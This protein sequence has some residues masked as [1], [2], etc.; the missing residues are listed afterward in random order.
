MDA[1]LLLLRKALND[2]EAEFRPGQAEAV[3]AALEPPFRALVVQA[4]GWGKSMVYFLATRLLRDRGRGPTLVVSPLLSL[5]RN[6]VLAA[7]N[8]GLEAE[9]YTS[10]NKDAWQDVEKAITNNE[11]DLLLVSPERLA[12]EQFQQFIASSSL[13]KVG[14]IVIDEAHCISDWG[15]DFR[16]DYQRLGD[17]VRHLP[18]TTAILATTATA[19]ERVV[20]DV[21]NQIG[22]DVRLVRGSLARKSLRVQVM[23]SQNAAERLAWLDTHLPELPGS[24]IIYALTVRDSERVAEWLRARGHDVLAY[25]GQ[26]EPGQRIRREQALLD[27]SVKALVATIALGMGFDKPDLGFVVH[28]QSPGNLV[29]YYQQ[30]GRAGRS[31]DDAIAILFVGDE[32]ADIHRFFVENARPH[33]KDVEAVLKALE[34]DDSGLST[35]KLTEKLNLK[36][37]EVEKILKCLSVMKPSPITKVGSAY[38]RIPVRYAH[39]HE[40]DRLL[41]ARRLAERARFEQFAKTDQCYMRLVR[42]ELDDATAI[43]CGQCSNC[44]SEEIV[45]PQYSVE[46]I[47]AALE[48]LNRSEISF[49]PRKKWPSKALPVYGF[50]GLIAEPLRC[51]KGLC[52]SHFGDPGVAA[53][54]REDKLSGRFRRDL[55]TALCDALKRSQPE[56]EPNWVCTVPSLRSGRLVPDFANQV[57]ERLGIAYVEAVVK[58]KQTQPQKDQRNSFHQASNLDGAFEVNTVRPGVVLLIDDMVDSGWTFTIIG[59][60]LKQAGADAVVPLALTSTKNQGTDD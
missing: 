52:L 37:S 35:A 49:E 57:A 3:M 5:M 21:R 31:V 23:T 44:V 22:A 60:L 53:W 7:T 40:K 38:R 45:S 56:L 29:A 20:E 14:L 9:S 55:V 42:Q 43:D 12:N 19:N 25:H 30:I 1:M 48:F 46:S 13:A 32:D 2:P 36:K 58:L 18:S 26:L 39:D 27:N 8:L 54:V 41:E 15:H 10:E 59:A 47:R 17:L 4:T 51:S 6:Q 11:V 50:T 28:Y 24:G 33:V 34:A 16:P